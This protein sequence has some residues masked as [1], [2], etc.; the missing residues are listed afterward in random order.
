MILYFVID[1]SLCRSCSKF[2]YSSV[3]TGY[4]C[5]QSKLKTMTVLAIWYMGQVLIQMLMFMCVCQHICFW[6]MVVTRHFQRERVEIFTV[7]ATTWYCH[8]YN[9]FVRSTVHG[10]FF[11]SCMDEKTCWTVTVLVTSVHPCTI[12]YC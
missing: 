7:S 10:F 4:Q 5:E 2:M 1:L 11:N 3:R 9:T 6:F 8:V 12:L